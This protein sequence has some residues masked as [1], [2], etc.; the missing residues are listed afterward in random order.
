MSSSSN[1]IACVRRDI[2]FFILFYP[3]QGETK[4]QDLLEEIHIED[5]ILSNR[6]K[7][8]PYIVFTETF[9]TSFTKVCRDNLPFNP[10]EPYGGECETQ[11]GDIFALSSNL[12]N[13]TSTFEYYSDLCDI[14]APLPH[15]NVTIPLRL[16]A[17]LS[18]KPGQK[19]KHTK[20]IDIQLVDALPSFVV[21]YLFLIHFT[22]PKLSIVNDEGSPCDC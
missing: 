12:P 10:D 20:V 11:L 17:G 13:T 3:V 6:S 4:C 1:I 18:H 9:N 7:S 21:D 5:S 8:F 2:S 16:K 22:K 19:H 14:I 15:P